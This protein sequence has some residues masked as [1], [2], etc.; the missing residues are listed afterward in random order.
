MIRL[1]LLGLLLVHKC[2]SETS[3]SLW[4]FNLL[5]PLK[6]V[7]EAYWFWPVC[8]SMH[9]SVTL[10][11]LSRTVRDRIL[12]FN[13]WNKHENKWTHIFFFSVR[14]VIAEL[15]PFLAHL[16]LYAHW[17][18]YSIDMLRRPSVLPP[19]P[20]IFFS[21]TTGPVEAKF[22]VE[23]PWVR[24]MKLCSRGL[25]QGYRKPIFC[26]SRQIFSL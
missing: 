2:L 19:F 12:K 1:G 7:E 8:L 24:G 26:R 20:K 15:C 5:C 4:Y 9:A 18:A 3:G 21:K 16:S 10:C 22:H 25:S 6:E 11:I 13:V 23:P 14:L 17:W